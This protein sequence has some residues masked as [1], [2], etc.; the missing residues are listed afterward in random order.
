MM[1][2]LTR[3]INTGCLKRFDLILTCLGNRIS[4]YKNAEKISLRMRDH[5]KLDKNTNSASQMQSVSVTPLKAKE[6][7]MLGAQASQAPMQ[8]ATQAPY[9]G[10]S[11]KR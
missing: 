4:F 11:T 10:S 1:H 8:E 3:Y 2:E 9:S 6:K 7:L 5:L